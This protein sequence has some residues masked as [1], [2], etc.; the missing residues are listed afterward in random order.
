MLIF[1]DDL[2]YQAI[3]GLGN[4]IVKTPNIDRLIE[5]GTSF[6]RAYNMGGWNGAICTASRSMLI[7]GQNLWNANQIKDRWRDQDSTALNQ[8]WGRIM[9]AEGYDTYMTG[10]WHVNA[11]A[12]YVFDTARNIRPGMP[13]G[14]WRH[15]GMG[16]KIDPENYDIEDLKGI[17]PHGYFRPMSPDDTSWSPSDS[18][19]GGFWEGGTHWS[20]VLK[21]DALDFISQAKGSANPFLMYLAFNAPHDPRQAPKEYL[22]LYPLEEIEVPKN[23]LPMYP[24]KDGMGNGPGLRDEALAPYPRTEYAIKVH[25][26]EYYAIISHMDHQIGLIL[27]ALEESG[28]ADDTYIFFTADHGLSV[29]QHGLLGKQSQYE[30]SMQVPLIVAGPE[31]PKSERNNA[32][33][34][35]QDLMPTSLELAGIEKP[36]YVQFNSLLNQAKGHSNEDN[37]AALYGA[38]VDLQRMITIDDHKLIVYP[39]IN[40]TLLFDLKNDPFEMEDLSDKLPKKR[41]ELFSKLV[42]LQ[43][44]MNDELIIEGK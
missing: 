38:Y 3:G 31:I 1:A 6:D 14:P 34:Y 21:D 19:E 43:T 35:Y 32:L 12:D 44:S 41:Q 23:W 8:T 20:E 15:A 18:T 33:V 28:M 42:E 9:A 25:L 22:D 11:P 26:Q 2:S 5:Q 37:Y 40:K 39:K 30:H 16:Q 24:Y 10:K 17:M 29:G 36:A 4:D 27:D 7:S 13:P